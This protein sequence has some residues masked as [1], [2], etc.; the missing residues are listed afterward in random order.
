[1]NICHFRVPRKGKTQPGAVNIHAR[2]D[3]FEVGG[4]SSSIGA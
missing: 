3:F 2:N 1:M 4:Q